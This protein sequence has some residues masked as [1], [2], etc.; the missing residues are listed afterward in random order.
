MSNQPP[1]LPPGMIDGRDSWRIFRIMAEFVEGFEV[2]APVTRGVTMFGSART[3]PSDRFYQEAHR[4][5]FLLAQARFAVMTGGGPGIMEAA[6]RGAHDA[7]GA[8]IGLNIV[9]PQ[10]QRPNPYQTISV[11]FRYFYVRKV[12]LVKY[13]NAFLVFPGGFGTMDELFELVT[14]VQTLKVHPVPVVLYGK[15]YWSGLLA[16]IREQMTGTYIS[17]GDTDIM[18]IADSVDE[19]VALV[20]EGVAAPWWHPQ[21]RD[22]RRATTPAPDLAR[23]TLRPGY[24]AEPA[25]SPEKV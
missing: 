15:S 22:A 25:M 9:L 17:E 19:A 24:T 7:G 21:G 8:S 4:I 12:M 14:L 2:L 23:V 5:A 10:E 20:K 6:N 1:A 13:A 3:K 18:R 11:D 16:W